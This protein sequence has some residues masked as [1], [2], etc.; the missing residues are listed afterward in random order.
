MLAVL[1]HAYQL[2]DDVPRQLTLGDLDVGVMGQWG[3]G[4]LGR[5]GDGAPVLQR[6]KAPTPVLWP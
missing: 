3:D 5:W 1:P 4:A 6:S 2:K